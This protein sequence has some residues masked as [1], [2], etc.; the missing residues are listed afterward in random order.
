MVSAST[1]DLPG[2]VLRKC[3]PGTEH[4]GS[5]PG[6]ERDVP[7]LCYSQTDSVGPPSPKSN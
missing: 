4:L 1:I 6:G 5:I 7:I 3:V 2:T